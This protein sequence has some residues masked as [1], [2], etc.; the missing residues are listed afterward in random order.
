MTTSRN[1]G[2]SWVVTSGVAASMLDSMSG[3]ARLPIDQATLAHDSWRCGHYCSHQTAD[4]MRALERAAACPT[5][6]HETEE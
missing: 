5:C 6:P 1:I 2:P 3:D 4:D